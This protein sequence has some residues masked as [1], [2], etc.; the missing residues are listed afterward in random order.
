MTR[1]ETIYRYASYFYEITKKASIRGNMAKRILF[2]LLSHLVPAGE[3]ARIA[4]TRGAVDYNAL[5]QMVPGA[6]ELLE[7]G[8]R[9][10]VDE[11]QLLGF[12]ETIPTVSYDLFDKLI[13]FFNG[14]G[15]SSF[16]GGKNWAR[17][18]S[19]LKSIKEHLDAAMVAKDNP[20]TAEEYINQLMQMTAYVNVLDGLAHNSGS[21]IDKVIDFENS[22]V[23]NRAI[24]NNEK[25]PDSPDY[26]NLK[27]LMDAKELSDPD[28][29]L[30]EILPTLE[31][32]SDA[33]L[34]MKDWISRARRRKSEYQG[35]VEEREDKL[36]KIRLK[37]QL[38][39]SLSSQGIPEIKAKMES[40]KL[41]PDNRLLEKIIDNKDIFLS[42]NYIAQ[43][44]IRIREISENIKNDIS[45]KINYVKFLKSKDLA[46]QEL[47]KVTKAFW[48]AY[49]LISD[50]EKAIESIH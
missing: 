38:I 26:D 16:M 18:T 3:T 9:V 45:L 1:N 39:Q 15:Q 48:Q 4:H 43:S 17:I 7:Y 44:M 24:R 12:P 8:T 31:H 11:A 35:S 22:D 49:S 28:D 21:F 41:L 46:D 25:V 14:P 34:T 42:L 20:D 36:K 10:A 37:K 27:R 30:Q 50:M 23:Q 2:S 40:W 47:Y 13:E 29:V 19:T 5:K 32:E 6:K 33:P